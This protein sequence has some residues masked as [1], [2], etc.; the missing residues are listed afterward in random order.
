MLTEE[1][2]K[3]H[4]KRFKQLTTDRA[5]F[6]AAWQEIA[7]LIYPSH[8]NFIYTPTQG[9]KR[10][11]KV[12]DST[13]IYCN[14]LLASGLFSLL[15]SPASRWQQLMPVD[16][17]LYDIRPVKEYL[18]ST[19]RIIHHEMNRPIA[20]FSTAMHEFYL[21]DGAFGNSTIYIDEMPEKDALLFNC[22]PLYE[23]YFVQNKYNIIDTMYRK[24]TRSVE[25]LVSKFGENKVSEKVKKLYDDRKLD[26]KIECC[27]II[28]PRDSYNKM[29]PKAVDK[30]FASVY[31]DLK[32]E[33]VMMES[34]YNELPFMSSR[35]YKESFETYGRGPGSTAL[36]DV[37]MLQRVMQVTIRAAQKTT[38]PAIILPDSGFLRPLRT[39]PNSLNYYRR[40]RFNLKNDIDIL[41]SGNPEFGLDY[42]EYLH[43]KIREIFFVDQL[44]LNEGPQMTA[45]EVIQRT[46]EKLR[47]MGPLLGRIQ[48]ELLSPMI[49]RVHNLLQR[50]GKL[51]PMPE[52]LADQQ[53]KITYTSPIARAQEQVEANGLLRALS[54]LQP[55]IELNEQSMILDKMNTDE[56]A[57]GVFDM[58]SVRP[59]FLNENNIVKQIREDRAERE[60]QRQEAEM[61]QKAG[62]GAQALAQGRAVAQES[63]MLGEGDFGVLQ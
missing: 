18:D 22:L 59:R 28:M 35:F 17:R 21:S 30:P 23:T 37:K 51:P 5:N 19:S 61:L 34:G 12:Y 26:K 44:Q 60:K 57:E 27:H 32:H 52:E 14:E 41:P 20:G 25:Q 40:G 2:I 7:E 63:G 48:T 39:A 45:T 43:R 11:Q 16:F 56:I 58:F 50:A 62:Q 1:Q 15:T 42:S 53:I 46:E 36:P 31:I 6:D 29:S 33:H 3:W 55:F 54:I 8:A 47:L 24:Y 38:D 9:E 49:F 4:K 13:G 10:M